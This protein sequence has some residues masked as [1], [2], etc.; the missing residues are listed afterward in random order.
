MMHTALE[1]RLPVSQA[2]T[3]AWPPQRL[4]GRYA[5]PQH[6]YR[7]PPSGRGLDCVEIAGKMVTLR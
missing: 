3:A 6:L 5:A 7:R 2:I 1:Y 4:N